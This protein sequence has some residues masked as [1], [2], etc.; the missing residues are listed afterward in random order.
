MRLGN[1]RIGLLGFLLVM[2][3]SAISSFLEEPQ[4]PPRAGGD[5]SVRRPVPAPP[6]SDLAG[7][8]EFTVEV[9]ETADSSG[10]AFAIAPGVW[11]TAR[12]VIDGCDVVGILERPRRGV[13]A[14]AFAVHS[15]ADVA[16]MQVDRS[17]PAVQF[18]DALPQPGDIAY[19]VG[20]PHGQPGELRSRMLG[21]SVMNAR[22]RYSTREPVIAWAEL[23]RHPEDSR[24]LSGLSGGPVFDGQG[25]LIGV[26]VAGSV[27][28]GRS[29][30]AHP[31]SIMEMAARA[32]VA[33]TS[34]GSRP[35]FTPDT[36]PEIA[37][38]LR[39]RETVV[40]ALC[41]VR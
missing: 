14:R 2:I 3:I 6:R 27:R 26:H 29:F 15:G 25:R 40:M 9:G 21:M 35:T 28:R 13:R 34:S 10:T 39:A 4:E 37:D 22:G 8:P 32:G 33:P 30:T 1:N 18:A 5:S 31:D 20:F 7:L 17:G 24:P 16:V 23:E 38:T 11:M 41:D 19:H 12:H 36:L